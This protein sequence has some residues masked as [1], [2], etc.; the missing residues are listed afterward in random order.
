M[1]DL[2]KLAFS[3]VLAENRHLA[4]GAAKAG[5]SDLIRMDC[6]MPEMDGESPQ[7]IIAYERQNGLQHTP[8]V[9]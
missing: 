8:I 5:S 6:Q 3:M 9:A 7:K 2:R 1:Y 4:V